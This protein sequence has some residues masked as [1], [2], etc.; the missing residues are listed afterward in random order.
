[1]NRLSLVAALLARLPRSMAHTMQRAARCARATFAHLQARAMATQGGG[2]FTG[3]ASAT[4]KVFGHKIPDTDTICSA[5]AQAWIFENL[6]DGPRAAQAY[7]LGRCVLLH[8]VGTVGRRM[9]PAWCL[10][11]AWHAPRYYG[12]VVSAC[13]VSNG[14]ARA[15]LRPCL[16]GRWASTHPCQPRAVRACVAFKCDA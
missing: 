2:A 13:M 6:R 7:R 3:A 11:A 12:G 16:F 8:A 4:I 9:V 15:W 10:K 5:M 14:M 1:M